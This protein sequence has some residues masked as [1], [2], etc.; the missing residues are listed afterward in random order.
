MGR[1]NTSLQRFIWAIP[2][3]FSSSG[4]L[5]DD[6]V[7]QPRSI[8]Q[9]S[10]TDFF[11]HEPLDHSRPS[12]RLLKISPTLSAEGLIQCSISH[13]T[14][15]H[16]PYLCLSYAW[17][18]PEPK[19]LVL[20]NGKYFYVQPNLFEFLK[21]T[22]ADTARTAC[23]YW[24]DAIC[25]DQDNTAER[26]HQVMQMG[27]IYSGAVTVIAWLGVASKET[28]LHYHEGIQMRYG[29]PSFWEIETPARKATDA[30]YDD[31]LGNNY[32]TRAW[33]TQELKLA[34]RITV[35][36]GSLTITIHKLREMI[37]GLTGG[38]GQAVDPVYALISSDKV[39]GSPLASL[40]LKFRHKRCGVVRDR[41]FSLLALCSE[42]NA[43]KVDYG[44]SV[45]E[46]VYSIAKSNEHTFCACSTLVVM[47]SLAPEI[48][49]LPP[50]SDCRSKEGPYIEIEANGADWVHITDQNKCGVLD[51]IC[52]R[53]LVTE[54]RFVYG[55][56]SCGRK[57]V[58]APRTSPLAKANAYSAYPIE[59]KSGPSP[60][61]SF[62]VIGPGCARIRISLWYLFDLYSKEH[63]RMI[64]THIC[65]RSWTG[66]N[67]SMTSIRVGY[68][69]WDI[70][71]SVSPP[72]EPGY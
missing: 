40:L 35:A 15:D 41:I 68:G 72:A 59:P 55:A 18:E 38:T 9:P 6:P 45:L 5:A 31:L 19:Q 24:I 14:I 26:N 61:R 42:T 56:T 20:M 33:I 3:P 21:V 27:K 16:A 49:D 10:P 12:I 50:D 63:L 66:T 67:E 22:R 25:I 48:D 52:S 37:R 70:N 46:L 62:A 34:R 7:S 51:Y 29:I 4:T 23:K 64:G 69:N 54:T 36:I 1:L 28:V 13:T 71:A 2:N 39:V 58:I 57:H 65:S 44:C 60:G 53:V 11:E 17:G 43:I 32:W 47:Q 30:V 8:A